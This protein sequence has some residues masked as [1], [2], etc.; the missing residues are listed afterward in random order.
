VS[1]P[2]AGLC[3]AK[4]PVGPDDLPRLRAHAHKG[5]RV[6]ERD[7]LMLLGFGAAAVLPLPG[8]LTDPASLS[9]AIE[10]LAAIVAAP[11][12]R[13]P[14]EQA[15]AEH[16]V[17]SNNTSGEQSPEPVPIALGALRFDRRIDGELIV[18]EVTV[19]APADRAASMLVVGSPD[20]VSE[21]V[22]QLSSGLPEIVTGAPGIECTPPP[23]DFRLVSAR[24]HQDFLTRVNA[25][26]AE[27]RS[28]R[29]DKVV[30]AREVTVQANRP[31]RQADLL[32]RLRALHPS[33]TTFALDGF[34][35]ATPELLIRRNGKQIASH[36][37]AGTAARSGNA[38]ADHRAEAALLASLKERSEHRAVV[39]AISSALAPVV[40]RLEVPDRPEILELRN[41]SHLGT[42]ITGS[43]ARRDGAFPSALELVGLLHPT[44]AVAGTPVDLALDYLAKLEELDRDRYAGPLGWVDA[45]AD[46]EWYLGIRS[47]IVAGS[48]ARLFAG[49]GIVADSDPA[50]ELAETQLKLQAFLAAAVRP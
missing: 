47:A 6:I 31:L 1:G 21:L 14:S 43:L 4:L 20:R 2:G 45:R 3:Y 48:S 38:E 9:R 28:G 11:A 29:L 30:L 37:L 23:D 39:D 40:E 24:P 19:F 16:G 42:S 5:G 17:A 18:P 46:G 33:C 36:P 7:G 25:A 49:V 41:V 32:G 15:G 44:P 8:G 13:S 22:D 34:I 26:L 27:I 35:G 12:G 10:A 50:E